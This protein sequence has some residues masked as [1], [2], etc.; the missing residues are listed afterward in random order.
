MLKVPAGQAAQV[1]LPADCKVQK[2]PGPQVPA[3]GPELPE[4][5]RPEP[6]TVPPVLAAK[7]LEREKKTSPK[8]PMPRTAAART[9]PELRGLCSGC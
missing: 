3:T 2:Y 7:D 4:V 1:P 5:G 9:E 8:R 6:V